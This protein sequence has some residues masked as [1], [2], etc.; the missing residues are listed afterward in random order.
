VVTRDLP[1]YD[2]VISP[3][4]IDGLNRFAQACGLLGQPVPYDDVVAT[5]F[6]Y[7]WDA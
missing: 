7:L 1:Y 4:A 2:P 5:Q 3:A 6:R